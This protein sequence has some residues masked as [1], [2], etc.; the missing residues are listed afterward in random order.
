MEHDGRLVSIGRHSLGRASYEYF[1][2]VDCGTDYPVIGL[3]PRC[4][5]K[6]IRRCLCVE[7]R[8][9]HNQKTRPTG[10]PTIC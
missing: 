10:G 6:Y 1:R 2:C 8:E 4:N 3:G 7:R 9:A 5:G